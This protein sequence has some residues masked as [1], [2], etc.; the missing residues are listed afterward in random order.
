MTKRKLIGLLLLALV[1][2]FLVSGCGKK[3]EPKKEEEKVLADDEYVYNDVLYKINVDETGYGI[4]Y[5][6][7]SNF[8][9]V[10]SGN[11]LNYYSQRNEDNSS[12]F[13]IRMFKYKNKDIKYAIKDTTD[14]KYDNK[15]E[16]EINGVKYTKIHFTNF[17]N[18]NTYIFY[19]THKKTTYAFCFTA[20]VEEE[21]LENI[22]LSQIKY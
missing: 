19:H 5:K 12:N 11:A 22:F 4:K 3:E 8:R 7:A 18:A 9:K 20:W 6:I 21:R 1:A 10:D 2:V 13:V 15:S 14:N 17:N 16:V